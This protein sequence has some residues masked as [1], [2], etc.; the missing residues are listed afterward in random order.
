MRVVKAGAQRW[1]NAPLDA[2][3][4]RS[5]LSKKLT[6]LFAVGGRLRGRVFDEPAPKKAW[7]ETET[8]R[9]KGL[10]TGAGTGTKLWSQGQNNSSPIDRAVN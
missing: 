5:K 10:I 1:P 3:S 6:G 8:R 4:Q 9:L 7:T 2:V